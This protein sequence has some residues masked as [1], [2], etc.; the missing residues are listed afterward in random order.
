M[1]KF[2]NEI[3]KFE[4]KPFVVSNFLNKDEVESFQK[5]YDKLPIEINNKRQN[6]VKK[7]WSIE[8]NK[9]LQNIYNTKLK[10]IIGNFEMDNPETKEGS[11]SLGLFQESYKPVNLHV[12]TGFNFEKKIYKNLLCNNEE[13]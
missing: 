9:E 12:D 13:N 11:K 5:L 2:I 7:K 6:I 8:F 3:K 1:H 4:G 10:T